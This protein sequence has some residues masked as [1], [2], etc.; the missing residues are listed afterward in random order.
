MQDA[1]IC[2]PQK[3]LDTA[4]KECMR[5]RDLDESLGNVTTQLS[6]NDTMIAW[7]LKPLYGDE[8]RSESIDLFCPLDNH[9]FTKQEETEAPYLHNDSSTLRCHFT[10]TELKKSP[11]HWIANRAR[12]SLLSCKNTASVRDYWRFLEDSASKIEMPNSAGQ[13]VY[14][15]SWA[16]F[17]FAKLDFSGATAHDDDNMFPSTSSFPLSEDFAASA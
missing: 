15:T 5:E 7:F 8:S 1:L 11:N 10:A 4:R 12:N 16:A 3:W 6:K 9:G 14:M 17:D 2:I 13:S